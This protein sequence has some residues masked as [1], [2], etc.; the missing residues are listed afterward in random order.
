MTSEWAQGHQ[1]GEHRLTAF[2]EDETQLLGEVALIQ[3][4]IDISADGTQDEWKSKGRGLKFGI[5]SMAGKESYSELKDF[6]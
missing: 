6:F 5:C 4:L 1:E 3:Q 2:L